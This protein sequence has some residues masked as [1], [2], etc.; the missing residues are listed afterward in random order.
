MNG[1]ADG[2][3]HTYAGKHGSLTLFDRLCSSIAGNAVLIA[4]FHTT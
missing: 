4:L 3:K 1:K 2:L